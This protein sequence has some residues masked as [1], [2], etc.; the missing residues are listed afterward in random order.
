MARN[1]EK[2]ESREMHTVE[3]W[4]EVLKN[5]WKETQALYNL[6]YVEKTQKC[7]KWEAHRVEMEYGEKNWKMLS[8]WNA[9]FK[10]WNMSKKS[11]SM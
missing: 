3:I 6:E 7:G 8:M 2:L 9:N 11:E 4:R 10:T 5:V 1:T